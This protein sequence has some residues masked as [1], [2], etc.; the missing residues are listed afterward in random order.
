MAHNVKEENISFSDHDYVPQMEEQMDEI[1][2]DNVFID[3]ENVE[4]NETVTSRRTIKK[5]QIFTMDKLEKQT[6][7]RKAPKSGN[8]GRK[9]IKKEVPQYE[10][11]YIFGK[12]SD[13]LHKG[14]I[15]YRVFW[16]GYAISDASWEPED[17]LVCFL[18]V[19]SIF[20]RDSGGDERGNFC[21][22]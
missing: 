17:N 19:Y 7:K 6:K 20:K 21:P 14:K 15:E 9:N 12:R 18:L 22:C 2:L 13:K 16:K 1:N 11:D 3:V 8:V 10:V 5:P 4:S